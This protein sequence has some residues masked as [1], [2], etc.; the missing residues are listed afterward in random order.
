MIYLLGKIFL[1]KF[2]ASRLLVYV[3]SRTIFAGLT[4]LL[5]ALFLGWPLIKFLY[6]RGLRDNP[7]DYMDYTRTKS[8]TPTMGGA[9]ILLSAG[10]SALLWCDL[11]NKFVYI[12]FL[13]MLWFSFLGALDDVLKVRVGEGI[14]RWPKLFSQ[15]S[16]GVLASLVILTPAISP[17]PGQLIFR[18]YLP[19]VKN[20]VLLL[21][22]LLYGLF[23]TLFYALVTNSVNLT[24]GLDGLAIVP[25]LMVIGLF[26]VFA[27]V[28]GNVKISGYLLFPFIPGAHEIVIFSAALVGAGIGFLWYNSYPAQVFLGDTGSLLLGGFMAT[29]A[30]L[31][32][33]EVLFLIAGG[34]FVAELLSTFVQDFVGIRRF[35]RRV[36]YRAPL[37]HTFQ[38][39]GWGE[40]KIVVRFWI[41]SFLLFLIA[42]SSLKIR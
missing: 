5:L 29:Q 15:L 32:K 18:F 23:I 35:K 30:V 38:H 12:L 26:G 36:L 22:P 14:S 8:G 7:R 37:H 17:L 11:S 4:S 1:G 41:I 39:M 25:S 19:F 33:Q 34:V 28:M 2:P 21:P 20:P 6:R 40:T 10:I 13:S 42:L 31:L 3:S 9:I 27:Y 24:D 16:F